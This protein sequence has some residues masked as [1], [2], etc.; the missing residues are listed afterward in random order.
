MSVNTLNLHRHVEK[1]IEQAELTTSAELRVHLE[2]F[3]KEDP[4]DRAAYLFEKLEMHQTALRNGVLIY[5]AFKDR[6]LAILGDAGIHR[7]AHQ[8][9]WDAIKNEMIQAFGQGQFEGGLTHAVLRVGET[10]AT[11]FPRSHD[12]RNELS[13]TVSSGNL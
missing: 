13:N 9:T 10:L 8:D 4:L 6:K 1:A 2:D 5:V 11:F 3:C 12:D 7:H